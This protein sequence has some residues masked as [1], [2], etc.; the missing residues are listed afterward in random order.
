MKKYLLLPLYVAAAGCYTQHQLPLTKEAPKN[1]GTYK[2]EYLF[3]HEGC[4][5]Y[6]FR[7]YGQ[8]VYFTNCNGEAIA[9]TDSTEVRNAIK[10][11]RH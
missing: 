11:S 4:K 5:V 9:K 2:V 10:V 3:E 1:N 6:R 7:D 8:Y